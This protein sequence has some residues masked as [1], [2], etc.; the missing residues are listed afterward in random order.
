MAQELTLHNHPGVPV[1]GSDVGPVTSHHITFY[2]AGLKDT[3]TRRT[4]I[5][6]STADLARAIPS[7]QVINDKYITS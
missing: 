3:T 6:R 7:Y 4:P 2:H 1:E 5:P